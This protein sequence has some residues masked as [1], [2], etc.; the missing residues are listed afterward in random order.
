MVDRHIDG[1]LV[2]VCAASAVVFTAC[3]MS[4]FFSSSADAA[5]ETADVV[6]TI[7]VIVDDVHHFVTHYLPAMLAGYGFGRVGEAGV[8]KLQPLKRIAARMQRKREKRNA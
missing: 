7:G 4:D 3:G 1:T 8:K 6:A 5:N 2:V